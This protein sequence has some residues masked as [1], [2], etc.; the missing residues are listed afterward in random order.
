MN[1]VDEGN[2]HINNAI[3]KQYHYTL[4]TRSLTHPL[5]PP[6]H[7]YITYTWSTQSPAT[8][9]RNFNSHP[10]HPLYQPIT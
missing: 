1:M 7:P 10:P 6:P 9:C 5:Y 3:N 2:A 8:L 4:L